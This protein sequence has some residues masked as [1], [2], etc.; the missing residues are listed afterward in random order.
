MARRSPLWVLRE[1]SRALT[2]APRHGN[3]VFHVR[4]QVSRALT[5]STARTG[6][7][8][9]WSREARDPNVLRDSLEKLSRSTLLICDLLEADGG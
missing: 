9:G 2:A 5:L 8:G 4:Q 3:T 6:K 1:E 7:L